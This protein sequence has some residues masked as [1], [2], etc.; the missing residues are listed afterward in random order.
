MESFC[1]TQRA[2]PD[3]HGGDARS[4][5]FS[6]Y[7]AAAIARAGFHFHP[8]PCTYFSKRRLNRPCT[9]DIGMWEVAISRRDQS[10]VTGAMFC[11]V[12]CHRTVST[13]KTSISRFRKCIFQVGKI[14]WISQLSSQNAASRPNVP[15]RPLKAHT[16][17]KNS[18]VPKI[19]H[20]KIYHFCIQNPAK[21]GCWGMGSYGYK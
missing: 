13:Q 11:L 5:G 19:Y 15:V 12:D 4:S 8:H 17:I 7:M 2:D 1:R 20:H 6:G 18:N 21:A 9:I 16:V 14:C 10:F 3:T